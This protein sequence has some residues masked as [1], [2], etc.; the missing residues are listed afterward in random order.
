MSRRWTF[1]KADRFVREE[2]NGDCK[3]LSIG[4]INNRDYMKVR[5]ACGNEFDVMYYQFKNGKRKCNDCNRKSRYSL[6]QLKDFVKENSTSLLLSDKYSNNNQSLKFI[7][8]CQNEFETTLKIF[9]KGKRQ[10]DNCTNSALSIKFSKSANEFKK[11]VFET[12][13]NEYMVVGE[14][15]NRKTKVE[16]KHNTC[17][18]E[19]LV[20]PSD[21]LHKNSR[22]PVCNES[23][24]EKAVS[25]W[26]IS[27]GLSFETQYKFKDCVHKRKLPF[28]F[29]VF[30]DGKLFMLIEYDGK[31][32]FL[33]GCFG[34]NNYEEIKKND[35]IKTDYCQRNQIPLLRI[36]Y[37]KFNQITTILGN[38]LL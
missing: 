18:T 3:L 8:H 28:D 36:P 32:H 34:T 1:E 30:K 9:R 12:V 13:N 37:T 25:E 11:E 35:Q 6:K 26:L 2:S 15:R 21:F 16:M 14:Y 38:T 20:N 29:A 17:G 7:C 23:K 5:C 31:Q 24:G 10:C 19:W 4:K 27:N 33:K 22:C